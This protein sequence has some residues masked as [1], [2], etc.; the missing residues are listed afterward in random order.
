MY[1]PKASD[2]LDPGGKLSVR[3]KARRLARFMIQAK[4]SVRCPGM[5]REAGKRGEHVW[6][7]QGALAVKSCT[8]AALKATGLIPAGPRHLTA[9]IRVALGGAPHDTRA[10]RQ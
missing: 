1:G 2:E 10:G 6:N 7:M 3:D 8:L 9:Q 4:V 5:K